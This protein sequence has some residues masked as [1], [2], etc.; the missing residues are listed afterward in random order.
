MTTGLQALY[1]LGLLNQGQYN[2]M[3]QQQQLADNALKL[4]AGNFGLQNAMAQQNAT[5]QYGRNFIEALGSIV[6]QG[7][8]APV[9]PETLA[10]PAAPAPGQ[11]SV[12]MTTRSADAAP[13]SLQLPNIVGGAIQNEPLKPGTATKLT[14]D[15]PKPTA[16]TS[17]GTATAPTTTD[18]TVGSVLNSD[19]SAKV[20][21]L[22]LP[23][24]AAILQ[25]PL[26]GTMALLDNITSRQPTYEPLL[27]ASMQAA[28]KFLRDNPNATTADLAAFSQIATPQIMDLFHQYAAET[29]L[30]MASI[31]SLYGSLANAMSRAEEAQIK[32]QIA[33]SADVTRRYVADQGLKGREL[34]LQAKSAP[35]A[36]GG[37][38]D[39]ATAWGLV[40]QISPYSSSKTAMEARQVLA[41]QAQQLGIPVTAVTTAITQ[42]QNSRRALSELQARAG[43]IQ[44]NEGAIQQQAQAALAAAK[45]LGLNGPV[46]YNAGKLIV[47]KT[48]LSTDDPTYQLIKNYEALVNEIKREVGSISMFGKSTVYG[49]KSASDIIK[50]SSG[51]GLQGVINGIQTGAA[52]SVEALERAQNVLALRPTLT[53]LENAKDPAAAAKALRLQYVSKEAFKRYMQANPGINPADAALAA[54]LK[55]AYVEGMRIDTAQ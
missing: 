54:L 46:S 47:G 53:L 41:Q 51:M 4:Q 37:T 19:P 35:A 55:G 25:G 9:A 8:S 36:P 22:P 16:F 31:M 43:L 40:Q 24:M 29:K 2:N 3:L 17:S 49:M 44:A 38:M 10:M 27:Q 23:D 14:L 12:P 26:R 28:Q 34:Q 45:S 48:V 6:P 39:F 20:P 42:S 50:D 18:N 52:A 11:P 1:T 7:P 33:Q 13:P 32:A 15:S 21:D 30:P 5:A